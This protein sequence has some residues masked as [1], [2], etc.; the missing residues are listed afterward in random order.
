MTAIADF[1]IHSKFSLATSP[2]MIPEFIAEYAEIKGVDVVGTGDF[3]H[4]EYLT[5]LGESLE[6][7][8]E[9]LYRLKKG[10]NKTLFI[11]TAEV[12]NIFRSN[13]K[14]RKIHT[15]IFSPSLDDCKKISKALEGLGKIE[16][17]GRPIFCI[18]IKELMKR[19]LDVSKDSFF[20]PAHIWTPWLSLLGS[21]S[22]FDSP[23]ECFGDMTE[24]I[25]ALETGLSSDP[26]MNRRVSSL[27]RFTIIS[28]SDAHSPS[29][30]GREA[31][32]FTSIKNFKSLK[33]MLM[34]INEKDK[35][36]HTLELYPQEGKYFA[37]GH[38]K[39]NL[40]L[41]PD[42]TAEY[43]GLCPNCGKKIT[44]GVLNRVT[45]LS[46]RKSALQSPDVINTKHL[47]PLE[48]IISDVTGKGKKT[49]TVQSLYMNLIEEA[50][51]EFYILTEA[52][53]DEIKSASGENI[54]EAVINARLGD[55]EIIPGFDGIYGKVK[56]TF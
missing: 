33:K 46:D 19:V 44:R 31:T 32:V 15:L 26:E 7:E 38:R 20:I 48:D 21:F 54:A 41:T 13:G 23:Q 34:K 3:I 53:K 56:I 43:K 14:T 40:N 11:P 9:G 25:F 29:V 5:I 12:C 51:N 17:N 28:N 2:L 8:S 47:I 35:L 24:N 16:S 39:C 18:H 27:D 6:E 22:G 49:K 1:H 4:P 55:V 45:V 30:I 42:E 52:G 37:D 36:L 50:G 10:R